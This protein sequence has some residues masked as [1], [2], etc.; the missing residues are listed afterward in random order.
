[1][2]LYEFNQNNSGGYFVTDKN[3]C[4]RVFIEASNAREAIEKAEQLGCYWDGVSKGIDC[5][6]CGNRWDKWIE[7][8]DFLN[9]EKINKDG[10]LVEIYGHYSNA[11]QLW[12]KQYGGYTIL[13]IPSWK[14][15]TCREYSG[16]IIFKNAEEYIQFLADEYGWTKPD[17]RIFYKDGTTKEI[18]SKKDLDNDNII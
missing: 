2:N 9:I 12:E 8:D 17:A 6:C 18:Y 3:M 11:K 5:S 10:Y 14:E 7:D 4:H 1:M 15:K 16:K 13:E